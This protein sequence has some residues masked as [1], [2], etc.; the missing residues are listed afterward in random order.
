ME[1]LSY[2][3]VKAATAGDNRQPLFDTFGAYIST[4][5]AESCKKSVDE[6]IPK[7]SRFLKNLKIL[8]K[9]LVVRVAQN[10][11]PEEIQ[12][13]MEALKVLL[14]AKQAPAVEAAEAAEAA[15]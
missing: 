5:T 14:E 7:F 10:F 6:L 2:E 11:T 15:V 12:A 4:K 8:Q 3:A 1:N 13:Q 9:D